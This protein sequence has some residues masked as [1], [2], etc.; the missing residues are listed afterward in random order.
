MQD[1]QP[2]RL[3]VDVNDKEIGVYT[4]VTKFDNLRS[5]LN[6]LLAVEN[7]KKK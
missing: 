5:L 3:C 6:Y 2:V 7:D 1:E 4:Q